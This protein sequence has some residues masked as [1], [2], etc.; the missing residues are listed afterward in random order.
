VWNLFI[1]I[2]CLNLGIHRRTSGVQPAVH[3][4]CPS[5]RTP[6]ALN[7]PT[8]DCPIVVH[9]HMFITNAC[10]SPP[11][12]VVITAHACCFS[13]ISS[14]GKRRCACVERRP[15][16][17]IPPNVCRRRLPH[18]PTTRYRCCIIR[19]TPE[20]SWQSQMFTSGEPQ[21]VDKA[22]A[23]V[24]LRYAFADFIPRCSH[25]WLRLPPD[26]LIY[27]GAQKDVGFCCSPR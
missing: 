2:A 13:L 5:Q 22:Q 12:Y 9:L 17:L 1:A 20:V 15:F 23:Q 6:P 19:H 14:T 4:S 25:S 3:A 10:P 8:Y 27:T 18:Q 16:F 7:I 26:R 21:C 11:R 24:A